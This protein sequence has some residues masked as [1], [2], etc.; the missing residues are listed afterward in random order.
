M[1]ARL[2]GFLGVPWKMQG[3]VTFPIHPLVVV[4][5]ARR[6][7]QRVLFSVRRR[8]GASQPARPEQ[9][10]VEEDLN[11]LLEE[12]VESIYRLALSI[13]RDAALAEDVVQETLIKA[14]RALPS[15]R[16]DSSLRRWVLTIAHNTS[17]SILRASREEAR[18]PAELPDTPAWGSV[19]KSVQD[20]L[21]IEQLWQ[22]LGDLDDDSRA[23]VVLRDIEGLRYEEICEILGLPLSTVRTRIFRVR[24]RLA[25]VLQEW[26]R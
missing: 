23:L 24:R 17:V 19:E 18:D 11:L 10:Q 9:T 5:D 3:T 25:G 2:F 4:F 8:V 22:A 12:H 26:R 7:L 20:K 15:F 16:G 1:A 13:V 6:T 21:V 14:W